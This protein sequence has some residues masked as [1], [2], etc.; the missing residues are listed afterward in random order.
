MFSKEFEILVIG[1][2]V[3]LSGV[4]LRLILEKG[5]KVTV[6]FLPDTNSAW[7]TKH[8]LFRLGLVFSYALIG[9]GLFIGFIYGI[10]FIKTELF[11]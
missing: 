1:L 7:T 2:L 6:S 3:G 4:V 10:E 8:F 5:L 9:I 11:S